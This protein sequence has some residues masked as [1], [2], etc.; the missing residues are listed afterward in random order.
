MTP[1]WRKNKFTGSS[2]REKSG[3]NGVDQ[4]TKWL[5]K[6]AS[7][8]KIHNGI[9]GLVLRDGRWSKEGADIVKE[10]VCYFSNLFQT[11]NP[12]ENDLDCILSILGRR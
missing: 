2:G 5:H 1:Y 7:L 8:R 4:N 9:D 6:K 3:S 11:S 10:F 12:S